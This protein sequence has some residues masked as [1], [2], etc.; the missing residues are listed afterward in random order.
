LLKLKQFMLVVWLGL[1]WSAIYIQKCIIS[2][3]LL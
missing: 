2:H 3:R 1:I